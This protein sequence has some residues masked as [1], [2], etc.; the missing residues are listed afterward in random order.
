MISENRH[1]LSQIL[2]TDEATFNSDGRVNVHNMHYWAAENP[3]WLVEVQHQGRWSLNVWC[4]ILGGNI[5]GPYFFHQPLNGN[6]F[7]EF[8]VSQ[9]PN[10]LEDVPLDLRQ[11]MFLQL[12]G[13]PAHFAV[14]VR[15]H[16]NAAF[17]QR[18]IGRGSLFPW[19]PRSPDLTCLDFYLWGR[20]KEI[21]YLTQP[22]TKQDMENRIRS[23]V[24][25]LPR[26]EIEAAV[27]STQDR[28]QHC[29]ERNGQQ[30]EHLRRH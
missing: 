17:P 12:D 3:H 16:L 27:R 25:Q 23:A 29:I 21:V 2:W 1:F 13:C 26:V 6:A 24:H 11:N 30:F 5:I 18:W 14:N 8:L 20:L 19:P 10:L 7:L 4:G 22:T 9:L 28:L 15:E